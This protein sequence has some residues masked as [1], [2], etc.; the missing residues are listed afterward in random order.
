MTQHFYSSSLSSLNVFSDT[1]EWEVMEEV[2]EICKGKKNAFFSFLVALGLHCCIPAF[3]SC[4][5][6]GLLFIEVHGLLVAAF[7][8]TERGL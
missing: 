3:S 7:L 2:K 5:E 6:Q 8:V 4:S 1:S